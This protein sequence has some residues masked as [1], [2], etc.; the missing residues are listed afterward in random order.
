MGGRVFRRGDR[1]RQ[2]LQE[3]RCIKRG[4]SSYRSL[5]ASTSQGPRRGAF[6]V[7]IYRL[8]GEPVAIQWLLEHAQAPSPADLKAHIL[9]H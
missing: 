4:H 9:A 5:G 2:L 8:H 7:A 1:L 6:T 3:E